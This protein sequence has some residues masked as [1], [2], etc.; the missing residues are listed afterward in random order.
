MQTYDYMNV[1][2]GADVHNVDD[3][4]RRKKVGKMPKVHEADTSKIVDGLEKVGRFKAPTWA[5]LLMGQIEDRV[6]TP[7]SK[8]ASVGLKNVLA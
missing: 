7:K 8:I 3:E 5:K 6:K 2:R 1:G 4:N